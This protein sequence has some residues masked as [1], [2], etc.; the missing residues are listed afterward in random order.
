MTLNKSSPKLLNKGETYRGCAL[1]NSQ[2]DDV[3]DLLDELDLI[4]MSAIP[5]E[6]WPLICEHQQAIV[7]NEVP[8]NP[9]TEEFFKT[10]NSRL[11]QRKRQ[12]KQVLDED[13]QL[14]NDHV[15]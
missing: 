11:R 1:S 4:P 7:R 9:Y 3:R 12:R 13:F 5:P 6:L 15:C 10:L 14:F 2:L 8:F